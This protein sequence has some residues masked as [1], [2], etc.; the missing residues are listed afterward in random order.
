MKVSLKWLSEYVDVPA[1]TKAF[2]DRLDL[3]GTGVE[4]VE[5]TGAALDGVVIGHVETCEP[6]PDSDHMHVV[7]VDVGAGE[8]V[9]IVCGAPNIAADIKVPVATVGAVLPG[10][11]KIKK[12]KLRGIASCGMCCSKRELGMGA[13]HEGIWVLPEDAP[14]G[15]PIADY[16][17]LSDTVL[18]LEITPNRPDCLSIVGFAREVG[19]MCQRDWTNPLAEMAAKLAPAADGA[20]VDEAVSVT[21]DDPTRCPRYT[22]RV[23]RGCKVGPSPD[24]MVER[25]AAI[26]QRSI[27]NVVD[28]TNYILFLFGQP[29]HAFD[30]DKL[31]GE[32]GRARVVI[33]AA[34]DGERLTTLDGEER[35]LTSD[36]TVIATPEQGAVALAGVMGGLDTEVTD[37]TVNILLEAATFEAGRTSRTSRNLGLISESSL[38]YERG[39]DDHGIEAR[40]A[41]AAALIVEVAGGTVSAAAGNDAGIVD[42]WP[43][44]SEPRALRF[45]MP[46][47]CAMMGAD[48]PRDF[49]EDALARLGCEVADAAS[50]ADA[51]S[52]VAPTFRP[53]L[54]R[55]IDLY[56]EVL[57]L[58]GM[59]RIPATLPGGPGRVGTRTRAEHVMDA[60][61]R[62]LRASG[63]NETMTYSFAEPG[64]LERLRMPAEG[65]GE[66]VELINPLNA[67]QSV[68]RQSIIPGLL[69]SVA[70]N[71]SRGVKNVQLYETGVVFYAH[72]GKK[73]PK[74]KRKVAGVLAGAMREAGWNDAPAAFDFF[75]GKG[76]VESLARELAL[77]KLRFKALS[78]D[79]APHLQPGRAA[80]VLSGDA[81]LGWVGELHPLAVDAYQAEAPVVAFELD[82]DALV[83][84]AR[85][86][87]DYV[88]VP[89]FPAVS[90]DVAFVV[91]EAV[92]C[93]KLMQCMSSAG[94]KLLEDARL[95]DVYR[96]EERV[97]AGKKSMAFALTY[98]AADRTL[99]SEEVDKAH[100]RLV[101]KVCAATGAEV[102][103]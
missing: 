81:E 89:T 46:R 15:M 55:E 75:D 8:P 34:E 93:E 22:A 96:D 45:R 19:A 25:L 88:D 92:T 86:A 3:T 103:G 32:D 73:Q 59:D 26:G 78:A 11:F 74:E 63:L 94:G 72:E 13:D 6:H 58:W 69:R 35:A 31:A 16:A 41:A 53:D 91:D 85:P 90:M 57:R 84:A 70:Y 76:V 23:I 87:R 68:M 14:V 49:V 50:D 102:R 79:E 38:R 62:T 40:S 48:I 28:V 95:F 66:P 1:D 37:D 77:P 80:V 5:K 24:W 56:E 30:L 82:V 36:M 4:G 10:D 9:Q 99:T 98:R 17:K 67:D 65:L 47:F 27:N 52:V 39:V 54:E 83:K 42:A 43:L 12:S 100:E 29:L 51:L 97:G 7:T 60:I 20:P 101:K 33:R 21:I 44:V 64:D 61:N 18:D 71:Q 2:C